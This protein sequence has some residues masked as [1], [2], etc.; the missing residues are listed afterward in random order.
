MFSKKNVFRVEL[1]FN[2]PWTRYSIV[3]EGKEDLCFPPLKKGLKEM[4]NMFYLFLSIDFFLFFFVVM[5]LEHAH[6]LIRSVEVY[7]FVCFGIANVFESVNTVSQIP[8]KRGVVSFRCLL[9]WLP[10]APP[11]F[12][13]VVVSR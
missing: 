8:E 13:C 3:G 1:Q 5:I 4:R 12:V 10:L 11:F 9:D 2:I 7:C 6:T